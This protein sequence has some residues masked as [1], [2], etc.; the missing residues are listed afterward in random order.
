MKRNQIICSFFILIS[1]C[2]TE[3]VLPLTQRYMHT[4]DMGYDYNRGTYMIVLADASWFESLQA[5]HMEG[6]GNAVG[7]MAVHSA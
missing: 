1:I 6:T 5:L 3:G 2:F 7:A 4:N